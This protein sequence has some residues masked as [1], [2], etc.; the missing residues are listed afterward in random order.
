MLRVDDIA[1]TFGALKA[2]D[3]VTL[4]FRSDAITALIGPNG[5]GKTT[6][7]NL[8]AG[9]LRPDRGAITLEGERI[10]G[11]APHDIFRHGVARTFQIPRP[12]AE[13]SVLDNL[14]VVSD[15]RPG[16]RFY[17]AW[18][19]PRGVA[20]REAKLRERAMELLDFV[21]LA[22]LADQPARVLSGGQQKLLELA[23]VLMGE[24]RMILL[25]E[26]A[27]GVNPALLQIIVE[28]I[29]AI[30]ARG[31]G[32]V[33]IEHNIDLVTRICDPIVVMAQGRVLMTGDAA[34]V[35]SDPRVIDAYLGDAP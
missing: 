31:I 17:D 8:M 23:R 22:P 35:R 12:F 28:R 33:V 13:M 5:A 6:L 25:D 21:T 34:A 27:A 26:P 7:F 30:H 19:A 1:V 16:E 11:L 20:R 32:F 2:V 10:D 4:D 24:P 15:E 3:G 18:I 29:Q 9:A 14:L